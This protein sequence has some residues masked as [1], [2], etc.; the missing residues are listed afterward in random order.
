MG[1]SCLLI[2]SAKTRCYQGTLSLLHLNFFPL[3]STNMNHTCSPSISFLFFSYGIS[4][5]PLFLNSTLSITNSGYTTTQSAVQKPVAST[6]PGSGLELQ[7]LS[8]MTTKMQL[9]VLIHTQTRSKLLV[10][11]T[12]QLSYVYIAGSIHFEFNFHVRFGQRITLCFG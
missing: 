10:S 11:L 3:L 6:S 5:D 2:F 9:L 12:L 1:L 4:S 7:N 8:P